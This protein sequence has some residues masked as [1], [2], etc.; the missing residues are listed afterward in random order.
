[1]AASR[2]GGL[3]TPK[4]AVDFL[5]L[6]GRLKVRGKGGQEAQWCAVCGGAS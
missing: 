5:T 4:A 2:P 3:A 6:V 1:M